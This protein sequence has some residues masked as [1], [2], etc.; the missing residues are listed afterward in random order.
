MSIEHLALV[1]IYTI[2]FHL[3]FCFVCCFLLWKCWMCLLVFVGSIL[4]YKRPWWI[5][6]T[7][8]TFNIVSSTSI[9]RFIISLNCELWTVSGL[10][11]LWTYHSFAVL[12]CL[13]S[14]SV[15]FILSQFLW[16]P[17]YHLSLF[18][19]AHSFLFVLFHY[20]SSFRFSYEYKMCHKNSTHTEWQRPRMERMA[21]KQNREK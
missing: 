10:D 5:Q 12:L 11:F 21:E 6:R 4:S 20:N 9:Q 14:V 16:L 13:H 19:S 7:N 18:P 2:L 3:N 17:F 8:I 15:S 1:A